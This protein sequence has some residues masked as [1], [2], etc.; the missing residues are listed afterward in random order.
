[1]QQRRKT[2]SRPVQPVRTDVFDDARHPLYRLQH[3]RATV[4][5][6]VTLRVEG[7]NISAIARVERLAWN[8]VARWLER[9]A[10]VCRQCSRSR[11]HR[12]RR[13]R[14]ASRRD[15]LVHGGE[16]AAGV[17]VRSD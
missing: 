15:P 4:D 8:T 16:E 10:A 7:V 6:V 9:A 14:A 17:G 13:H 11:D 12:L 3:R 2:A 5:T 1:M